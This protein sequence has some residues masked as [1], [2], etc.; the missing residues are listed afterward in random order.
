MAE[1]FTLTD[2]REI[3]VDYDDDGEPQTISFLSGKG[4]VIALS[5]NEVYEM[6]D[7]LDGSD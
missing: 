5:E 1:Q 7:I 6:V 4:E 2:G 3:T